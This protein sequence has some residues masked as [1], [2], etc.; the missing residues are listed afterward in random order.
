MAV[1]ELWGLSDSLGQT[2]GD[3]SHRRQQAPP[4]STRHGR[5]LLALPRGGPRFRLPVRRLSLGLR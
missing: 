2:D 4:S 3:R 1:G 5:E